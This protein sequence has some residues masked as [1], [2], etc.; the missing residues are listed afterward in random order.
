MFVP[1]KRPKQGECIQLNKDITNQ[2][3]TFVAPHQFEVVHANDDV[4]ELLDREGNRVIGVPNIDIRDHFIVI[5][6]MDF[7]CGFITQ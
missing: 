2:R 5:S 1:F 6:R 7:D 3:G 4:C